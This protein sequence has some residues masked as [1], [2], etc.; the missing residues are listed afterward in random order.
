MNYP[1]V[2]R[3]IGVLLVLEALFMLPAFGISWYFHEAAAK[4]FLDAILFCLVIG[5]LCV[6]IQAGEATVRIREGLAVVALGWLVF[7]I[8]GAFPLVWSGSVPSM[9]DAFLKLFQD[10]RPP[11]LR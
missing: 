6:R 11:A 9:T 5:F 8:A 4:A 7:S 3:V 1:A 10:S 2:F